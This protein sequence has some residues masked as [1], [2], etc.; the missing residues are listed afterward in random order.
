MIM[1][2]IRPKDGDKIHWILR[3]D[4]TS[5]HYPS[6]WSD[7]APSS[8]TCDVYCYTHIHICIY[9]D[10]YVCI[11]VGRTNEHIKPGTGTCK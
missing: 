8:Y 11:D 1:L 4:F 7:L 2:S 3:N 5:I 9:T 10:M 6:V